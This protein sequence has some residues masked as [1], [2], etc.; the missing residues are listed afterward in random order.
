M[1]VSFH[2]PHCQQ[3]LVVDASGAGSMI[4]CPTCEAEIS[5][6]EP[7]V[8]SVHPINAIASSAAAKE[9]RH[10][11]VPVRDAPSEVLV[12]AK[13]KGDDEEGEGAAK[14]MRLKIFRHTDYVEV[15]VDNYEKAVAE[16]LNKIGEENI[17]SITPLVYSHIDLGTQ[18]LLQD[19]AMQ[20]LYRR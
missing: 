3:E 15:G 18:K 8:P 11:K 6:P 10:F 4:I 1:D 12:K 16:F 20:V 14:K 7:E 19:Y 13:A 2:C 9:E 17:I 5:I